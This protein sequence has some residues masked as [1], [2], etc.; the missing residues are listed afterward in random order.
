MV[1]RGSS[2]LTTT[3]RLARAQGLGFGASAESF[4]AQGSLVHGVGGFG[5][6]PSK[7]TNMRKN[8]A[9]ECGEA[10]SISAFLMQCLLQVLKK[11]TPPGQ[12]R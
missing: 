10:S 11:I 9:K 4:R 5:V 7:L 1:H 6:G 3:T 8:S 2:R 12:G